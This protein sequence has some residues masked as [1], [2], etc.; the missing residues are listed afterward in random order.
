MTKESNRDPLFRNKNARGSGLGVPSSGNDGQTAFHVRDESGQ[1]IVNAPTSTL[2]AGLRLRR[3][4]FEAQQRNTVDMHAFQE[5]VYNETAT[6][7]RK[8]FPEVGGVSLSAD[9]QGIWC[10]SAS[11]RNGNLMDDGDRD[12]IEAALNED[13]PDTAYIAFADAVSLNVNPSRY[14][15]EPA[16]DLA[17]Y[18]AR[19]VPAMLAGADIPDGDL[20]EARDS[21]V[22]LARNEYH[23]A[24]HQRLKNGETVTGA[25]LLGL[26]YTQARYL[27]HGYRNQIVKDHAGV[28]RPFQD[29][30]E[31]FDTITP[32]ETFD[33][34]GRSLKREFEIAS[35]ADGNRVVVELSVRHSKTMAGDYS[36]TS[37]P[38]FTG[39]LT[40]ITERRRP[41]GYVVREHTPM[42]DGIRFAPVDS[43]RYSEK[44]LRAQ[45]EATASNL[46]D[47]WD[48]PQI[49]AI[50]ERA[51]VRARHMDSDDEV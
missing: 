25:Q 11:N 6:Y 21:M 10:V 22:E 27:R 42:E 36:G 46:R 47:D 51:R 34:N 23:D 7:L 16:E 14:I 30:D 24:L 5:E 20:G 49:Q 17:A 28:D 40:T 39:S 48:H 8:K 26:P 41:G 2:E 33:P 35:D 18:T 50:F 12:R 44:N 38:N 3:G 1:S 4:V 37:R 15:P 9:E 32:R 43:G 31:F 45:M 19:F 13:L 29:A